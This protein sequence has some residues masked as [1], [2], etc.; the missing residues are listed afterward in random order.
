LKAISTLK[1][2]DRHLEQ[3]S[4]VH[5]CLSVMFHPRMLASDFGWIS[6]SC[7]HFWHATQMT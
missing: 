3:R 1:F 5:A 6:R 4:R 2:R 7:R